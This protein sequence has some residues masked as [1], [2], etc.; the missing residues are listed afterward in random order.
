MKCAKCEHEWCYKGQG[1]YVMCP[2]C[3]YNGRKEKFAVSE[4]PTQPAEVV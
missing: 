3:H 2:K 4:Q 1:K